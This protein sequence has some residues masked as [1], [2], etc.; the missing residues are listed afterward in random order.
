LEISG[1]IN[2]RILNRLLDWEQKQGSLPA[3]VQYFRELL[4][5]QNEVNCE[6]VVPESS[7]TGD[8]CQTVFAKAYR[9]G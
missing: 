7:L 8:C 1:D 4:A 5:I 6:V 2:S 9:E 3:F